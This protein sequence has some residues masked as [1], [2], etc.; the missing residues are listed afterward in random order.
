LESLKADVGALE[1]YLKNLKQAVKDKE[2]EWEHKN[3]LK[4]VKEV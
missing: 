3:N 4:L 1:N 2:K